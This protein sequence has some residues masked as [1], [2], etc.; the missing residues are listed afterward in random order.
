MGA[1]SALAIEALNRIFNSED[2]VLIAPLNWGLGHA[3]RCIPIIQH[4]QE[5]CKRVIIA[6]DG[7]SL[8][9]LKKE[10]PCLAFESLPSYRIQ[11][12]TGS[13][14]LNMALNFPNIAKAYAEEKKITGVLAKKY[15]VTA[16]LSDN[17][18]GV[19][20]PGLKNVYMTH[21]LNI[22]HGFRPVSITASWI[23][24]YFIGKFDICLVPDSMSGDALAPRLSSPPTANTVYI[25][26]VSRISKE[27]LPAVWDITVLLSGPEPQRS[28][29]EKKLIEILSS[30]SSANILLVRGTV[31]GLPLE[32]LAG[33]IKVCDLLDSQETGKVLN[34]SRLLICRSGYSTI[35]DL[36]H[37]PV[38]AI[39][40]PTPGQTEQEYLAENLPGG[41]PYMTVL[42]KNL[43]ELPYA[44]QKMLYR[45]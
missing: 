11:Y 19:L 5:R 1:L 32:R 13:A 24:R 36:H 8:Q 12:P 20:A 17:R 16:V 21:Q 23:H 18:P 3:S 31:M 7:E 25:G 15:G 40:I 43:H 30:F 39:F 9:L 42:Q 14:V 38:R 34:S 10:F 28:I 44:V 4:L 35:M 29:L 45:I 41:K 6:S 22:L 27:G 33:N 26:P 2:T 37:L